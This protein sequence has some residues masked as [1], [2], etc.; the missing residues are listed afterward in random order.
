[1]SILNFKDMDGKPEIICFSHLRWDFVYQRPQHL[2]TRFSGVTK[3]YFFE[4]YMEDDIDD[5]YLEIRSPITNLLIITP[6]IKHGAAKESIYYQ[7]KLLD[8]LIL[9]HNISNFVCW[10]Y[11][12]MSFAFSRHLSPALVV[13]D[14]MDELSA[15][16]DAPK[17]LK[18]NEKEL[19]ERT[20][21]VFTGGQSLYK[22][23]L[24]RHF[25]VHCFPSSIDQKHFS[26]A[27]N[28]LK[29]PEDQ[30]DIPYPRLG[31][32]GVLDER[33]DI[34]LLKELSASMPAWHFI[35]I[36]PVVKINPESLPVASNI[37][38][39]GMKSYNV[40]PEYI[41]SWNV[42]LV[43]FALNK[44]TRFISPTK[45]PE[46]LAAGK[47]VVSTPIL[48]IVNSYGKEKL[49]HIAGDTKTFIAAVQQA[50]KQH[51]DDAWIQCVDRHLSK[52][53]WDRTWESMMG[54]IS[55]ALIEENTRINC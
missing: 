2:M 8:E 41:S 26:R 19:M 1:M 30:K 36:G 11:T 42:A 22:A 52:T 49:I 29:E 39:L 28:P 25:N 37:H 3:V 16:K 4:E 32:F 53:S 44:S 5:P 45:T 17:M 20:D 47:P 14:C 15:F 54:L 10:Y 9:I 40:L 34:S 21:L 12:P 35:L 7:K 18:E 24:R 13:Y 55:Q 43:L 31:F 6:H 23:K 51:D 46:Y 27:R 33:L 48:D 50:M 38:Y